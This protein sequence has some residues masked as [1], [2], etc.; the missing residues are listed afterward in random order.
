V[1]WR[2]ELRSVFTSG[3]MWTLMAD[4]RQR[5]SIRLARC[6]ERAAA[7]GPDRAGPPRGK[8]SH[9]LPTLALARRGGSPHSGEV[10]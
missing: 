8:A 9:R 4:A 10:A 3:G 6:S 2:A 5:A 1:P 7:S